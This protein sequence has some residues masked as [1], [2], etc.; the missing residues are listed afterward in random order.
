FAAGTL[1]L[2]ADGSRKQIETIRPGDMV[3]APNHLDPESKPVSARVVRFFD[4]GLKE[5][6]R[7]RFEGG[8]ELVCTPG[9]RFYVIGQGWKHACDLIAGDYCLSSEGKS[10]AFEERGKVEKSVNVY[11]LEVEG[12][13]TYNVGTTIGMLVH[14]ECSNCVNG[15]VPNVIRLNILGR[16]PIE[17]VWGTKECPYCIV[18]SDKPTDFERKYVDHTICTQE[19]I[20]H[21]LGEGCVGIATLATG[22]DPHN[23]LPGYCRWTRPTGRSDSFLFLNYSD[24]CQFY[25][26][27]QEEGCNPL[28]VMYVSSNLVIHDE[29]V[30]PPDKQSCFT[31][32][33]I[34]VEDRLVYDFKTLAK[35]D[36]D[37]TDVPCWVSATRGWINAPKKQQKV[38]YVPIY[39]EYK[40]SRRGVFLVIPDVKGSGLKLT[41]NFDIPDTIPENCLPKPFVSIEEMLNRQ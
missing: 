22:Y 17:F 25:K 20:R 23:I 36:I 29:G 3:L 33:E 18:H 8:T 6:V 39:A 11:N 32:D 2:M 28:M 13:H 30:R 21:V 1:V 38:F 4:N 40:D 31:H 41:T 35:V 19:D 16:T 9:H 10:V 37:G 7:V 34:Q 24:A 14:N 26:I 5:V 12:K 15:R 27:K